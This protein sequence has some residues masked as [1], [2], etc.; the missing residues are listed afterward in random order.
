[1]PLIYGEGAK[2]FKGL[3]EKTI[4]ETGRRLVKTLLVTT[5]RDFLEMGDF[6]M[7]NKGLRIHASLLQHQGVLPLQCHRL[8][9]KSAGDGDSIC[10][11]RKFLPSIMASY[12]YARKVITSRAL[13]W[14]L[15]AQSKH[16]A[17]LNIKS[18]LA[19]G[20]YAIPRFEIWLRLVPH[21]S[22]TSCTQ[23]EPSPLGRSMYH[24]VQC[25]TRTN[26]GVKR[27]VRR[28]LPYNITIRLPCF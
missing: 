11:K 8:L 21:S 19:W 7:T 20:I 10:R 22:T 1:M 23:R 24:A 16:G 27:S 3:Q 14:G 12:R 28:K 4:Q 17:S 2:A 18:H 9:G 15:L 26:K 13:I 25:I 6:I 5:P